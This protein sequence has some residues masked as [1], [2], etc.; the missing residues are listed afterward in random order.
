MMNNIASMIDTSDVPSLSASGMLVEFSASTWGNSRQDKEASKQLAQ[1]NGADLS[2]ISANK[3]LI[4]HPS[5]DEINKCVREIRR[6][7]YK[8]TV[9]WSDFN[10]YLPAP[11]YLEFMDEYTPL[12]KKH[13]LL[14]ETF[15]EAYE[16]QQTGAQARLGAMFKWSD[17]PSIEEIRSRFALRLNVF[18]VPESGDYRVDIANEQMEVLKSKFAS[19]YENKLRDIATD[20][21]T[22]IATSVDH[23]VETLTRYTNKKRDGELTKLN[24]SLI[25]NMLHLLTTMRGF[26]VTSDPQIERIRMDMEDAVRGLT[27]DQLKVSESARIQTVDKFKAIKATLPTLDI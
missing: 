10:S 13:S 18:P 5:L 27:I 11:H 23:M 22:Q 26:N 2:S 14:C 21:Y 6:C 17:Y 4:D 24:S 7:I 9:K 15:F 16:F 8:W 19:F 12:E 3:K 20:V 1:L 25:D